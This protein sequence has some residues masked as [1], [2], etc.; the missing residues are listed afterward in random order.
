MVVKRND[1]F[2]EYRRM[3][4]R[5]A[6]PDH[7]VAPA[8]P[9]GEVVW[10]HA[11]AAEDM[12]A[13]TDLSE[14]LASERPGLTV[15]I[16]QP[17]ELE[18]GEI[19][20]AN[21]SE[22]I[23]VPA[24]V[25][26]PDAIADFLDHWTPDLCLWVWGGLRPNL[27]DITQARGIPLHLVCADTAGFDMRRERWVPELARQLLNC[28]VSASTRSAGCARR[29]ARLGLPPKLITVLPPLQPMGYVLDYSETDLE[30]LHALL[31][32]RPVW[33]AAALAPGEWQDVLDAHL[34]ALRSAHRLLVVLN[35]TAPEELPEIKAFLDTYGLSHAT[36]PD[37]EMPRES[38]QF[39]LTDQQDEAGLWYRVATVSFLG[40][41]LAPG[42]PG[43]D[44]I[45]A[46]QLGSAVL[47]GPNTDA[48]TESYAR[49]RHAK[50]ARMVQNS[51][52]LGQAVA[53]LIVPA[54]T[55]AMA[56][57]GWDVATEGAEVVDSVIDLV[58]DCLDR[59]AEGHP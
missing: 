51:E 12:T 10:V 50:A 22:T 23:C 36:W 2:R 43:I 15:L 41:S 47:H 57:A 48:F 24:P 16:T 34:I 28:F 37:G 53:E 32:G 56:H 5:K 42:S 38:T 8:R 19:V 20:F 11:G 54:N 39:V 18:N 3:S 29:L 26:H 27:I 25:E 33:F 59:P 40:Q 14:R 17:D 13:L 6:R 30:D 52:A 45:H 7:P 49:L 55:A 9:R 31:E 4:R 1:S 44:P 46:L 21:T 58:Q 35:V